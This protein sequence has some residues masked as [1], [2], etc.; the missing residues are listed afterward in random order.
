MRLNA[1]A[2][3]ILDHISRN[4]GVSHSTIELKGLKAIMLVTGGTQLCWGHMY[5]VTSK[6]LCPGVYSIR[7]EK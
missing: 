1:E 7:L 2:N 6:R 4:P 5:Q 3:R